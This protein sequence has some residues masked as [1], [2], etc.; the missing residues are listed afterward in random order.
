MPAVG[1]IQSMQTITVGDVGHFPQG[2]HLRW[3]RHGHTSPQRRTAVL[4]MTRCCMLKASR[5]SALRDSAPTHRSKPFY[6]NV[7]C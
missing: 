3:Q 1:Y 2:Q 6:L 7:S 4:K 5:G